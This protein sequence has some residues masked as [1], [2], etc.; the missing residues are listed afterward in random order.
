MDKLYTKFSRQAADSKSCAF[1]GDPD[2]VYC[3]VHQQAPVQTPP[4]CPVPTATAVVE[5]DPFR[6]TLRNRFMGMG[7]LRTTQKMDNTNHEITTQKKS[8]RMCTDREPEGRH[9]QS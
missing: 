7:M 3:T 2:L 4:P 5:E 9:R 8:Q 1:H 6:L